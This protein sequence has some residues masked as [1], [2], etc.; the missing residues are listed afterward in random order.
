MDNKMKISDMVVELETLCQANGFRVVGP[1]MEKSGM[2]WL[3]AMNLLDPSFIWVRGSNKKQVIARAIQ[4]LKGLPR[5][6]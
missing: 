4:E 5:R 3:Q 6:V 2:W 1:Q